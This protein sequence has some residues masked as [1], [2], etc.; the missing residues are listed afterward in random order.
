MFEINSKE[1]PLLREFKT[2]LDTDAIFRDHFNAFLQ[3]PVSYLPIWA[4]HCHSTF[5]FMT[6]IPAEIFVR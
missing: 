2:Q 4:M 3:L 6:G 5:L 1:I